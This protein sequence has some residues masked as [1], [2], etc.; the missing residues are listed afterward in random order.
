MTEEL[1]HITVIMPI[2]NESAFIGRSLTAVLEQSYPHDRMEVL[3]AD[4][5]STDDTREVIAHT[6]AN[7]KIPVTVLDNLGRIVPTGMNVAIRKARGEIV[8]RVD[9]HAVL[10][11]DYIRLCV[12]SLIKTGADCV[13]GIVESIGT[14][15]VGEAIAAAMSS[16]FGVGGSGFRTKAANSTP[17]S[18]NT[19]PFGAFRREV[20]ERIGLFNEEMVRHQDYEFNYRLR[21]AGGRILLLPT[22]VAKYYVR[23]TISKLCKQYWQYGIWK[24]RFLRIYPDSI[25]LRHL[26]PPLFVLALI[27]FSFLAIFSQVG[28]SILALTMGAYVI[29]IISAL[30][31]MSTNGKFKYIPILSIIFPCMHVSWGIGVWLGLFTSTLGRNSS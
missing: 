4:G 14:G 13:G 27:F 1:P 9:G 25:K 6:T 7:Q 23:S 3:I 2:R 21:K 20:F 19:V 16:P 15:Y 29:F 17:L 18:T 5:M 12:E 30:I 24:G 22:A 8:V 26:I 31:S 11:P 10:Q 28:G